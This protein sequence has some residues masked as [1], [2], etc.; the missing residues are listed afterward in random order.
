[1]TLEPKTLLSRPA[2]SFLEQCSDTITTPEGYVLF[3]N[4]T[5]YRR[6]GVVT[7][8]GNS[9]RDICGVARVGINGHRRENGF[10]GKSI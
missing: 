10:E 9:K 8:I 7:L 6:T 5:T 3:A 4:N 2:V 1:M